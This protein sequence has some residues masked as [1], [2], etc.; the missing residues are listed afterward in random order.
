MYI[1]QKRSIEIGRAETI[2][3]VMVVTFEPVPFNSI[4]VYHFVIFG[5]GS[6]IRKAANRNLEMEENAANAAIMMVATVTRLPSPFY[7]HS[8]AGS[9]EL[10]ITSWYSASLDNNYATP[11]LLDLLGNPLTLNMR[12]WPLWHCLRTGSGSYPPPR[13]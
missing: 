2:V 3:R 5:R 12:R 8:L 4:R 13:R 1:V 9:T 7:L 10:A 11:S 6:V